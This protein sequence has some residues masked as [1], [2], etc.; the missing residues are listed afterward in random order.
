MK[1]CGLLQIKR[2]RK[3]PQT[4]NS[5]HNL[6]VYENTVKTLELITIGLVWV[7]DITYIWI[8]DR[9]AYLAL[10]MDQA[11]KIIVGWHI[12]ISMDRSLCIKALQKALLFKDP[13]TYHHSDRGVQYCSYD[14]I[15]ILKSNKIIPSMA[16]VGMSVDNPY[17]ESLNRSIK[18]EEV[19][20]NSYESLKEARCSIEKYVKVYNEKRLHSSLGYVSPLTFEANYKLK[21]ENSA[22]I[23]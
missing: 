14:Y 13:P 9:W 1:E 8:G 15:D 22:T 16:S 12:D 6:L 20:L 2:K 23:L 3:A 17:A 11:S 18:V 10:V 19:Y 21:S 7:S 5:K 4:T